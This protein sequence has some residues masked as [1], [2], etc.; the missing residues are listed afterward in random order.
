MRINPFQIHI[1]AYLS[2]LKRITLKNAISVL[3]YGAT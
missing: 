1:N 2:A 3:V